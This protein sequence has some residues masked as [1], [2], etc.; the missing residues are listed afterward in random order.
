M[1]DLLQRIGRG[2]IIEIAMPLA[3]AN[4]GSA[5]FSVG[6]I[7]IKEYA[8]TLGFDLW[9]EGRDI[10]VEHSLPASSILRIHTEGEA[11]YDD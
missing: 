9:P 8:R 2:R 4:G 1:I 6:E 11:A 5:G 7:I 3:N 10:H